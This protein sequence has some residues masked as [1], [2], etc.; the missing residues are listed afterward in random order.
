[1]KREA[2][3]KTEISSL[4]KKNA[5]QF[6][7]PEVSKGKLRE[8]DSRMVVPRAGRRLTQGGSVQ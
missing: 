7:L 1:M 4:R 3:G 2:F 8:A 5:A 6:H